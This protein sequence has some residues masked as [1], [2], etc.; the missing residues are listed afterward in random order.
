MKG[1][2]AAILLVL[3]GAFMLL[4]NLGLIN[5]SLLGL[6]KVWWPLILIVVG[7]MLFFTPGAGR[8]K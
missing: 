8:S 7:V 5:V 2:F 4:S 6:L 3:V 1:N